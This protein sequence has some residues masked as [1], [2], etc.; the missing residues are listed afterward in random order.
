[1][2][3]LKRFFALIGDLF[4]S[5]LNRFE[6]PIA[7]GE[8]IISDL[9]ELK[10]QA[11]KSLAQTQALV[12]IT[13]KDISDKREYAI[14]C[15][16]KAKALQKRALCGEIDHAQADAL[17][18]Q[19]IQSKCKTLDEINKLQT[20][21]VQYT[22]LVSNLELKFAKI[23]QQITDA[24]QELVSLRSRRNVAKTL[25]AVSE[26]TSAL[27]SDSITSLLKEASTDIRSEESLAEAYESISVNSLDEQVDSMLE[28][29]SDEVAAD[30]ARIKEMAEQDLTP[31]SDE[32]NS[33]NVEVNRG[34]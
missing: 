27:N 29:V 20:Q 10:K 1:M 30:L 28:S 4:S 26:A 15:E 22:S 3:L 7:K 21:L 16:N 8:H 25:R 34:A 5:L 2:T 32:E 23:K 18:T 9:K 11:F 6:D 12:N 24:E 14:S 19:L 31:S 13:S 33:M 17:S